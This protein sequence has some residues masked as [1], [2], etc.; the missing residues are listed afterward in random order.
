MTR[1]S[2][3]N[4]HLST[5][6]KQLAMIGGAAA[7]ALIPTTCVMNGI[8]SQAEFNGVEAQVRTLVE[9]GKLTGKDG[10]PKPHVVHYKGQDFAINVVS[11][12]RTQNGQFRD[13]GGQTV[14]DTQTQTSDGAVRSQTYTSGYE[15]TGVINRTK[16]S[17]SILRP[18]YNDGGT[19]GFTREWVG[20]K[21]LHAPLSAQPTLGVAPLVVPAP[22]P[23]TLPPAPSGP[24]G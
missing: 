3:G 19:R 6:F 14:Q 23:G 1:D 24:T 15:I 10:S 17:Q 21:P 8:A 2:D 11:A 5:L 9:Q 20:S 12:L 13:A 4:G 7:M 22:N 18:F 16:G